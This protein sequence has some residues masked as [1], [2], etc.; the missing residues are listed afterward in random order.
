MTTSS[1]SDYG[2]LR[3]IVEE[4]RAE[5]YEGIQH[6]SDLSGGL[7]VSQVMV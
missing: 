7:F 1:R 2:V 3:A 4:A 6:I 5:K